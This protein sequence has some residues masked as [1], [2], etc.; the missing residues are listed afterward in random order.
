M[1]TE[2]VG[3]AGIGKTQSC[4]MM[5]CQACLPAHVGGLGVDTGVVFLD[6]ERKVRVICTR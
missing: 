4:L 6:T 2:I 5:A 1:I 3:P